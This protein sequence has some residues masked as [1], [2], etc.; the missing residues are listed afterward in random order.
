MKELIESARKENIH[1][2]FDYIMPRLSEEERNEVM[3]R[4][5][6]GHLCR[7]T[8]MHKVENMKPVILIGPDGSPWTA[9]NVNDYLATLGMT[10]EKIVAD[11]KMAESVARQ[12]ASELGISLKSIDTCTMWDMYWC[13]AMMVSDYWYSVNG[14][15]DEAAMLAYEYLSDPDRNI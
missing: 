4:L 2:A 9:G 7:E 12:K 10:P 13:F 5:M 11:I 6:D 3:I 14:S 8:A 1:S 15:M